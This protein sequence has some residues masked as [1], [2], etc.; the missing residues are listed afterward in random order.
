V[1]RHSS[2]LYTSG[3]AVRDAAN[4]AESMMGVGPLYWRLDR[5]DN[6]VSDRA[7]WFRGIVLSRVPKCKGPGAPSVLARVRFQIR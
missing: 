6:L 1:I 3:A 4:R 7:N 2:W 5:I